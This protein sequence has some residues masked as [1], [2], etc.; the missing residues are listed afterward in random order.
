M[1]TPAKKVIG[2]ARGP[3]LRSTGGRKVRTEIERALRAIALHF[4]S[5]L[6]HKS[7]ERTLSK[8]LRAEQLRRRLLRF[9]AE[10][11]SVF[12]KDSLSCV[13][14]APRSQPG[15][16]DLPS[17][18]RPCQAESC[19]LSGTDVETASSALEPPTATEIHLRTGLNSA[20]VADEL[21]ASCARGR[22]PA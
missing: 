5:G 7:H 22:V 3:P 6:R 4:G 2:L 9:N 12:G 15:L 21:W 18:A 1:H 8:T 13:S 14:S 11:A 16:A 17:Q 19:G 10:A 20:T